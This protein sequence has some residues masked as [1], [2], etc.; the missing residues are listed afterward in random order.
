V[1]GRGRRRGGQRGGRSGLRGLRLE[2][3]RLLGG[4]PRLL[5]ARGRLSGL[6]GGAGALGLRHGRRS[7]R[8]GCLRGL[9]G[10][11]QPLARGRRGGGVGG[12]QRRHLLGRRG[13][14]PGG[15]GRLGCPRYG[16]L[17]FAGPGRVGGRHGGRVGGLARSRRVTV[18]H[19]AVGLVGGRG[20]GLVGS[21]GGGVVGRGLG[22]SRRGRGG[23]G[24]RGPG[25][26]DPLLLRR[27]GRTR[28]GVGLRGGGGG[29]QGLG[30]AFGSTP[31][32][33]LGAVRVRAVGVALGGDVRRDAGTGA[34]GA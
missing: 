14:S 12:W 8:G 33:S 7:L 29:R 26:L 6:G 5:L 11:G 24:S 3:G 34:V 22:V 2:R 25:V 21:R 15:R 16:V 18:R 30:I 4:D 27:G 28:V 1:R 20:G 32:G 9:P 17:R 23:L 10:L 31:V 13:R 19:R